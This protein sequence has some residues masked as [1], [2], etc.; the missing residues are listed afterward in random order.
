MYQ[1]YLK[2]S[3]R[4]G[5]GAFT[6]AY[7]KGNVVYAVSRDSA[8]E[9]ISLFCGGTHIPKV[10]RLEYDEKSLYKMP[11]YR[12]VNKQQFPKAWQDYQT[13]RKFFIKYYNAPYKSFNYKEF[14]ELTENLSEDKTIRKPLKE[15]IIQLIESMFNYTDRVG[16]EI[17]PRNIA[18][19]SRKRLVL[20]DVIYN[21]SDL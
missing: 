3:K 10:E 18:V 19:D 13:I 5:R 21:P 20:L 7:R 4:I 15:S 2:G 16:F 6:T 11:L 1:E 9:C 12:K 8:K 17:S 14:T